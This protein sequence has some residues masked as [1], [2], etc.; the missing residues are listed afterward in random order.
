MESNRVS[1]LAEV[2]HI[3]FA[4]TAMEAARIVRAWPEA[5]ERNR[6]A[7]RLVREAML[8]HAVR[9]LTYEERNAIIKVL[10]DAPPE[11]DERP[12]QKHLF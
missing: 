6:E 1:S 4:E 3:H 12:F 8:A 5:E 10:R 9:R 11:A 2:L 7:G